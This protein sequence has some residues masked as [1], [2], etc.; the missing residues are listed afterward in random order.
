MIPTHSRVLGFCGVT[1]TPF[2]FTSSPISAKVSRTQS[3]TVVT[4]TLPLDTALA[5]WWVLSYRMSLTGGRFRC[6][7]WQHDS[8]LYLW[9]NPNPQ[10]GAGHYD[11]LWQSKASKRNK[12]GKGAG[13]G[14]ISPALWGKAKPNLIPTAQSCWVCKLSCDPGCFSHQGTI[15]HVKKCLFT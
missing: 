13:L 15:Q 9:K 14:C 4:S 8:I 3:D 7:C 11:L 6:S 10:Q 1:S 2:L 5:W 12:E